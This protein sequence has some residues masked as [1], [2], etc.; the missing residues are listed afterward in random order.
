MKL[1]TAVVAVS[2]FAAQVLTASVGEELCCA[3]NRERAI[4]NLP[5]LLWVPDMDRMAAG[6]CKDMAA[7]G[8]ISHNGNT[9]ATY[10]LTSRL[11]LFVKAF[12][13]KVAAE[14]VASGYDN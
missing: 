12:T 14:N 9:P 11:D 7:K 6:Q 8:A 2:A 4:K 10:Q 1:A 13:Y 3:T 5:A